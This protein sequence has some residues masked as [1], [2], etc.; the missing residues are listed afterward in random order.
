[1]ADYPANPDVPVALGLLS[2]QLEDYDTAES[3]LKKALNLGYTNPDMVRMYLGQLEERRKQW[4]E[5]DRW[6]QSVGP[7]ENFLSAQI[8]RAEIMAKQGKLDEARAFLRQISIQGSQQQIQLVLAEA[9]LLRNAKAYQQ[10]YDLLGRAL[11]KQPEAPELLY[12]FAMAAE[13][14][15]RI[16]VVESNLRKLIEIQPNYAHAYNA[17]G[18]TLADRTDRLAEARGL[19]EK[20]LSL[21]PDDAYILDSMGWVQFRLGQLV[22][23]EANLRRA[24]TLQADPEIAAH[25]G[26]VLWTQGRN[27]EARDLWRA[28]L[29]INPESEALLNVM[30]RFQAMTH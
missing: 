22:E 6:Y 19:I 17:L 23:A 11:Q 8:K 29:Q 16:D 10:A 26:E 3:Y 25:L 2:I 20:A 7:G 18:Y 13:R 14:L 4:D 15:N 12:D 9:Q 27:V 21:S 5:A 30:K 1:M 28:S 24:Y